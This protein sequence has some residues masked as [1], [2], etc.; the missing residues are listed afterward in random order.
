MAERTLW[1]YR[2]VAYGGLLG[3]KGPEIEAGMNSLGREGWEVLA[4]SQADPS[5]K[6]IAV[7]K[8]RLSPGDLRSKR[9]WPSEPQA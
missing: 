9:D 7:A 5:G 3:A 6:L 8:R 2:V 1:E 4:I